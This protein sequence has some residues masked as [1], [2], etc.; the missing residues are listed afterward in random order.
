[1]NAVNLYF[2]AQNSGVFNC[3]ITT[4]LIANFIAGFTEPQPGM[5][6]LHSLLLVIR[7]SL[8]THNHHHLQEDASK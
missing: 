7:L 6:S 5:T 2:L 8:R 4:I 3:I 1:M